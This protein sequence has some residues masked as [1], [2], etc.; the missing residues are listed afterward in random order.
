MK[1]DASLVAPTA[2]GDDDLGCLREEIRVLVAE[3]RRVRASAADALRREEK[4]EYK[5]AELEQ[6]LLYLRRRSLHWYLS[7][8][9]RLVRRN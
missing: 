6:Q 3:N 2:I 8:L 7:L 1:N 5:I 4:A 9:S